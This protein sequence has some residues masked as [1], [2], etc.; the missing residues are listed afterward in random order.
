MFL[1]SSE[2]VVRLYPLRAAS[3]RKS[4]LPKALVQWEGPVRQNLPATCEACCLTPFGC[5]SNPHAT[6]GKLFLRISLPIPL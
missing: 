2:K 6:L 1:L 4:L 5:T 3:R